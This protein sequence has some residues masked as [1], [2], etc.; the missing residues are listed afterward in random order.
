MRLKYGAEWQLLATTG[1]ASGRQI[2]LALPPIADADEARVRFPWLRRLDPQ[3][4]A[5]G[6]GVPSVRR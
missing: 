2:M 6:R 3:L 4:R 5:I 1:R